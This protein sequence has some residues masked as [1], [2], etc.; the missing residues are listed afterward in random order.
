MKL[1]S[2]LSFTSQ[3]LLDHVDSLA[4]PRWRLTTTPQHPYHSISQYLAA[5]RVHAC[6]KLDADAA[7]PVGALLFVVGGNSSIP[8]PSNA[9]SDAWRPSEV[10]SFRHDWNRYRGISQAV[11]SLFRLCDR[12][13]SCLTN[14]EL[15]GWFAHDLWCWMSLWVLQ[16]EQL[17]VLWDR[18]CRLYMLMPDSLPS[19]HWKLAK[20][21][22][23]WEQQRC[24][25]CTSAFDHVV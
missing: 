7:V 19:V 12:V 11:D 24:Y 15:Q 21:G 8:R 14:A 13:L 5:C 16:K 1:S 23:E 3:V 10:L 22:I 2:Q 9:L 20:A 6:T 18:C 4:S 25:C 17:C